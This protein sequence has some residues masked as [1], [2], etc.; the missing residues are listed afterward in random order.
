MLQVSTKEFVPDTK[1]VP[2]E[3]CTSIDSNRVESVSSPVKS[4][5]SKQPQQQQPP[6]QQQ[7]PQPAPPPPAKEIETV[8]VNKDLVHEPQV[9][10]Q[11]ISGKPTK[12]K[13]EPAKIVETQPV[14]EATPP[15]ELVGKLTFFLL[16]YFYKQSV[17]FL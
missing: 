5:P 11:K 6:P 14:K 12:T 9:D 4:K 17:F 3:N 2:K 1:H 16:F 10:V 8:Y 13:S 15:E 7:A